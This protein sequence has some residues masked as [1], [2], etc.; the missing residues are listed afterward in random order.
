MTTSIITPGTTL[1]G[2]DGRVIYEHGKPKVEKKCY[3]G[4]D[5]YDYANRLLAATGV[6]IKSL[7]Q[8]LKEDKPLVVSQLEEL[9]KAIEERM[10]KAEMSAYTAQKLADRLQGLVDRLRKY[11]EDRAKEEAKAKSEAL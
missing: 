11:A 7:I 2:P 5:S 4:P 10:A 1:G 8:Q 9:T 6:R 3:L